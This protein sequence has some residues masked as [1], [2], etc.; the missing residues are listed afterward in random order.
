[1]YHSTRE[2]W[3][4]FIAIAIISIV[5]LLAVILLGGIP[6]ASDFFGHTLGVV[7]FLL[8]LMTETLY[9]LRKRSRRARW[10]RNSSWLQFHIVTGLVGPYM[11]LLHSSWKFNG[12]AGIVML[13]TGVVVISGF[14]GRYIYT[15]IPRTAD[16]MEIEVEELQRQIDSLEADIG[17]WMGKQPRASD[18]LLRYSTVSVSNSSRI[19]ANP[20]WDLN[21]RINMWNQRRKMDPRTRA[22]AAALGEL[23]NR[24][25]S[26]DRQRL[27]LAQA[28]RLMALWHTLHVPIGLALFT[29]AFIHIAAAIYYATLLR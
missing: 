7:G 28:R 25:R 19:F 1:M 5:Y 21:Y 17:I 11:V 18:Q 14:I 29:A 13:M 2:L 9:T 22:Q 23:L 27:S 24:R 10:G 20:F 12:L 16:G 26:L 3:V 4:A 6:A 15:A 8:M